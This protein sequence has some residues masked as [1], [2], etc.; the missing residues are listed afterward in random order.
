MTVQKIS[1]TNHYAQIAKVFS[2]IRNLAN[3]AAKTPSSSRADKQLKA[4][5]G[6]L[7]QKAHQL[8]YMAN[9]KGLTAALSA[10][11]RNDLETKF[12]D[13]LATVRNQ[14]YNPYEDNLYVKVEQAAP[15]VYS[16]LQSYIPT[17][18]AAQKPA[19]QP[20][21]ERPVPGQPG[22]S[23]KPPQFQQ[24]Q[25]PN[26]QPWEYYESQTIPAPPGSQYNRIPAV[27]EP[28]PSEVGIAA[29]KRKEQPFTMPPA[30][31]VPPA[32]LAPPVQLPRTE[33]YPAP[34]QPLPPAKRSHARLIALLKLAKDVSNN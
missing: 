9:Y 29:P 34:G 25:L 10:G 27:N 6:A 2:S 12:D 4:K 24:P 31:I 19:P 7:L 23:T 33:E 3:T 14:E 5:I 28:A 1:Q 22:Y 20:A 11:Y 21:S 18:I 30:G 16:A 26:K 15:G 32:R 8:Y 13:I 17:G